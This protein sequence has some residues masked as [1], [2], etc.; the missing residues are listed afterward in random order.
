MTKRIETIEEFLARGGEIVKVEKQPHDK[1]QAVTVVS[2]AGGPANIM[3]YAEADLFYGERR[4]KRKLKTTNNKKSTIDFSVLPE[5]VRL[6][7][8][9]GVEND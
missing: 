3:S 1:D 2:N 8:L 9:K 6:K 5:A 7:F 4:Q